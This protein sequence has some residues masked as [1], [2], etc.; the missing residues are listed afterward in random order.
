MGK[1]CG[2][3]LLAK[4]AAGL[5]A[6][7]AVTIL[8]VPGCAAR[9]APGLPSA[10]ALQPAAGAS[11]DSAT[12]GARPTDSAPAGISPQLWRQLSAELT[13]AIAQAGTQKRTAAVPTGAASAVPDFALRFDGLNYNYSWSYR[14]QGDYDLNGLVNAADLVQVGIHFGQTTLGPQ[15]IKSQLADGDGN[16][17]V[18]ISD[19]A[20]IG[21]NFGGH[22]DG[23]ELQRRTTSA[24]PW[25]VICSSVFVPGTP[26]SGQYPQ[27]FVVGADEAAGPQY[28]VIPYVESGIE[29][30]YGVP[31]NL[32]GWDHDFS[33]CWSTVRGDVS[34]DGFVLAN[35]PTSATNSKYVPL[36]DAQSSFLMMF[37][38][39]V[40]D[41]TGNIYLGVVSDITLGPGTPG[42]LYAFRRDGTLRWRFRTSAGIC[43]NVSCSRQGHVVVGDL[44]GMVYSFAP[45]GKLFWATQLSDTPLMTAPLLD[46][47]GT[48]YIVAHTIIGNTITHS[49]LYKLSVD[50]ALVWSRDL[51]GT[52]MVSPVFDPQGNIAVTNSNNQLISFTPDGAVDF[53]FALADP[54]RDNIYTSGIA[55]AGNL[56][57]YC[58]NNSKLRGFGYNNNGADVYDLGP[59]TPLTMPT[60]SCWGD[61]IAGVHNTSN[62]S[63][64]LQS[65]TGGA[66]NW[67]VGFTCDSMSN[68]ATDLQGR[69]YFST[70]FSAAKA[71]GL[72]N[73]NCVLA[74]QTKAWQFSTGENIVVRLALISD[75][76]L[77]GTAATPEG[78]QLL[79]LSGG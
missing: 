50:G 46:A 21:V 64:E 30:Y 71:T 62:G 47:A 32:A 19:V 3:K 44:S 53:Q 48:V 26:A 25:T 36:A 75:N 79:L 60:L 73:I 56:I 74:D 8:C 72:A 6:A 15:W 13:R 45:D 24:D 42:W 9:Q 70:Y 34:R 5:G 18:G 61:I 51:N 76:L 20:P 31:S 65:Y 17:A 33:R 43:G 67:A 27:Y 39:P 2:F 40:G 28:Q 49:T 4:L 35:G 16:G 55:I 37:N 77:A 11:P 7:W 57:Y 12:P 66:L 41:Y 10:M 1:H 63:T 54:Q 59:S 23:Y 22:L 58:T 69:M 68:I 14:M 52:S 38:E 29:R 78:Y